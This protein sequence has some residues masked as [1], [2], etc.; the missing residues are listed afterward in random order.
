MN[1][2]A[3]KILW[4]DAG[5]AAAAGATVLTL[6][7]WL[8][9]LHAFPPA[10]IVFVGVSNLAYASYSGSLAVRASL[11]KTPSRR[12][13]EVLVF[14]NLAWTVVC[15]AVL[16]ATWRSASVFGLA[17]VALEGLF[18]G[19]LAVAERRFVLPAAR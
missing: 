6:R 10:L 4:L 7:A 11:D 14:A 9:G 1:G 8:V 16:A 18:V 5:A 2:R 17:H 12:A 15:A 19:C 3:R 13:V